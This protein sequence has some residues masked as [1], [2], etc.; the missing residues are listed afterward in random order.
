MLTPQGIK[1]SQEFN[2]FITA[3][4]QNPN[5][6]NDI[7]SMRLACYELE[8]PMNKLTLFIVITFLVLALSCREKKMKTVTV[9]DPKSVIERWVRAM[10]EHNLDMAVSCFDI[11]YRDEAPARRGESVHG[12]KMVRENFSKLFKGIPDLQAELL[13]AVVNGDT[14]WM[15]WRMKGTRANREPFEFAGVNIFGVR[16]NRITWGRIYTELVRDVGDVDAQLKRMTK[17]D[18][19]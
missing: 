7:L 11:D 15:E 2:L 3:N 12:Q 8:E 6:G 16:E 1:T 10:N 17:G 18:I 5:L 19:H 4:A 14:V 9:E 13:G